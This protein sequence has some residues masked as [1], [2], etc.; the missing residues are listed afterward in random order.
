MTIKS[1]DDYYMNGNQQ[2]KTGTQRM[3]VVGKWI[4]LVYPGIFAL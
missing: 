1:F 4:L 2:E 3:Y